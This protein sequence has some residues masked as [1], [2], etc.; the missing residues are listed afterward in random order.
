MKI[1][2][3]DISGMG[4]GYEH[5]CQ[6]ML[7]AAEEYLE[8]SS[9]SPKEFGPWG[10]AKTDNARAFQDTIVKAS[11]NDCTGAMMDAVVGNALYIHA[12]G[13]DAW[14]RKACEGN[15]G[16]A[17]NWDGTVNSI[18][19]ADGLTLNEA[20]HITPRTGKMQ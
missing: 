4:G 14:L 6:L 2:T 11:G 13:R 12:H 15:P 16:R 3:I 20:Q 5:T 19:K 18:P 10:T 9:V 17:Y 7:K 1:R 8:K